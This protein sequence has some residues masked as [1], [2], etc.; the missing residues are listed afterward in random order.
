MTEF[1]EARVLVTD[2]QADKA[3]KGTLPAKEANGLI[4]DGLPRVVEF[5]VGQVI[6][7]VHGNVQTWEITRIGDESLVVTAVN[8]IQGSPIGTQRVVSRE[9]LTKNILIGEDVLT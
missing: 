6:N 3:R 8:G 7:T 2:K 4:A 1:K 9:V 5:K